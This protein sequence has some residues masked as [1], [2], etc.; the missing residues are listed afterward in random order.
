M[1]EVK[2]F[3]IIKGVEFF[4]NIIGIRILLRIK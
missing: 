2:D 1:G 3:K 4:R